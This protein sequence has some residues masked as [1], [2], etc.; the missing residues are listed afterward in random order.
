ML[1]GQ[2]N[3]KRSSQAIGKADKEYFDNVIKNIL[4]QLTSNSP[5]IA[6]IHL[7]RSINKY[8]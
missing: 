6:Y 8:L 5:S 7:T 3:F 2:E 1:E 4:A